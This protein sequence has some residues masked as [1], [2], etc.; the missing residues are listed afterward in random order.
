MADRIIGQATNLTTVSAGGGGNVRVT[1]D[2]WELDWEF[3]D[4]IAIGHWLANVTTATSDDIVAKGGSEH[5]GYWFEI[6]TAFPDANWNTGNRIAPQR[7]AAI[8]QYATFAAAVAAMAE[9]DIFLVWYNGL[10]NSRFWVERVNFTN[11]SGSILGMLSRNQLTMNPGNSFVVYSGNLLAQVV[12]SVVS[13]LLL[14]PKGTSVQHSVIY[15]PTAGQAGAGLWA[16][17]L[18]IIGGAGRGVQFS[19]YN[20]GTMKITNCGAFG[21]NTVGFALSGVADVDVFNC[22]AVGNAGGGFSLQNATL[23]RNLVAF[24]NVPDFTLAAGCRNCASGDATLPAGPTNL[25][26]QNPRTQLRFFYDLASPGQKK[27]PLDFR[28]DQDSVLSA[29]GVA[30]ALVPRDADGRLRPDPPSIGAYEPYAVAYAP[31]A[32]LIRGASKRGV[33]T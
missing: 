25:L 31:A 2:P 21:I 13:N 5:L 29:A 17:R 22:V 11:I 8:L 15:G 23:G 12:Q 27:F 1:Y 18:Y 9:G 24:G 20:A 16:K 19:N 26:S 6:S 3:F 10:T 14:L 32:E 28:I 7:Q 30:V 33:Q 4:A